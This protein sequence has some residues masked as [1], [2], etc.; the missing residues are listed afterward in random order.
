MFRKA[1]IKKRTAVILGAVAVLAVAGIA[2]A[3]WTTTGSGSGSG[4]V[5]SSNGTLTLHGTI[6]NELTPGG[7]SPVAFT[8]DN[9][10]SSSEQVGTVHAVVS[11]DKSHAEA[12]CEA[13]DFT[14]ADTVENQVIAAKASAVALSNA[15]SIAM[16]D[17]SA[18][19]DAC[20]GAT[21]SLAL[22]S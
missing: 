12:G 5:A 8:A 4:A 22:T 14:I 20:K 11:I 1:I 15:G 9:A 7:S 13:S 2:I 19:Q 17:T 10:N 16:A 3:Y 6:S 21:I 18:N